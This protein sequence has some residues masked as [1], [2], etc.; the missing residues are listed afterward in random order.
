MNALI[1]GEITL[2]QIAGATTASAPVDGADVV[3]IGTTV[4]RAGVC[5][6][7]AAR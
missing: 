3:V 5:A 2:L 7:G 1:A 4:E 6:F